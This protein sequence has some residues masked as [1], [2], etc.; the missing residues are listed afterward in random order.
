M[1]EIAYK[2]GE[3]DNPVVN[4]FIRM[5]MEVLNAPTPTKTPEPNSPVKKSPFETQLT[6]SPL[7]VNPL[8]RSKDRTNTRLSKDWPS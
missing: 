4:E 6:Q 5:G 2:F 7:N 8:M 3:S 1:K